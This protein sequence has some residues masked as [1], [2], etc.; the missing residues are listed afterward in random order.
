MFLCSVQR[1]NLIGLN[2][3]EISLSCAKCIILQLVVKSILFWEILG[4]QG[5]RL[6]VIDKLMCLSKWK[7]SMQKP[8]GEVLVSSMHKVHFTFNI[9][10]AFSGGEEGKCGFSRIT[11]I[12]FFL[13]LQ[14]SF[15]ISKV[16]GMVICWTWNSWAH[17]ASSCLLNSVV[18]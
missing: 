9:T 8:A 17:L 4:S 15:N 7:K 11:R 6:R 13:L 18:C 1:K 16:A 5:Y 2:Q 12:T 14:F 3:V 10:T